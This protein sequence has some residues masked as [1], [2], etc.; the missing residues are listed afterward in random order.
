MLIFNIFSD[1]LTI[2]KERFLNIENDY[3]GFKD[4]HNQD[5][6]NYEN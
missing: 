5:V 6:D 4:I 2:W 1:E 3:T